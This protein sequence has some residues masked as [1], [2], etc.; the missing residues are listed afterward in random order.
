MPRSLV[1]STMFLLLV[2]Q[3]LQVR[4]D[5]ELTSRTVIKALALYLA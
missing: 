3:P 5:D 2:F 1:I 4:A